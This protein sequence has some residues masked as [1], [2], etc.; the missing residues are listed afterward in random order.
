MSSNIK[1]AVTKQLRY[2]PKRRGVEENQNLK[3]RTD[4]TNFD[5]NLTR[6]G[7]SS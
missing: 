6:N 4:A 2:I 3:N 7:N 5:K 1:D